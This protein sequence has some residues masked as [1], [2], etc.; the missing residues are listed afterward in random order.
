MMD[1]ILVQKLQVFAAKLSSKIMD[2]M[3]VYHYLTGVVIDVGTPPPLGIVDACS[4]KKEF[5]DCRSWLG[6]FNDG[7]YFRFVHYQK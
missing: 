2:Q 4:G 1:T 5:T 7:K 3:G 6:R